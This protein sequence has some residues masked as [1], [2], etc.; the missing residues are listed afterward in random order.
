MVKSHFHCAGFY[1]H[2][3]ELRMT[4]TPLSLGHYKCNKKFVSGSFLFVV[5]AIQTVGKHYIY[6]GSF[7]VCYYLN[8]IISMHVLKNKTD[9]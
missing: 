8:H 3:V 2:P 4:K 6:K 1:L 7:I 5:K 9:C